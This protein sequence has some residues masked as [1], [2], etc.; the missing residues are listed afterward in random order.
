VVGKLLDIEVGETL[1]SARFMANRCYLST[2]VVMRDP[3]FVI[4][5]KDASEPEIL[6]YLKIPGFT[7]YLHPYDEHH[8]IG[9]GR[10]ENNRVRILLFNV[11]D[12]S[13]PASLSEYIF[14]GSWSDTEVLADH[15]AFLFA[16]SKNLLA[17]PATIYNYD[18]KTEQGLFLFNITLDDG[19]RLRGKIT[20]QEAEADYWNYTYYV[21][22]ALYI[23]NVLYTLS[24]RK[25]QMNNLDTMD[26]IGEIM[27]S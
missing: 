3:F 24:D 27:L 19:I 13:A 11:T 2:S 1:D 18:H 23:E 14:D 15:R 26:K 8:V 9:V 25:I 10:D 6:G 17:I 5:V 7:R 22:R 4:D 16:H 20:H 12:V 21:R